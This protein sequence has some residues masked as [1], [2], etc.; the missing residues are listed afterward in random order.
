M[1]RA[2]VFKST[3]SPLTRLDSCPR[4]VA[5]PTVFSI[6]DYHEAFIADSKARQEPYSTTI[7]HTLDRQKVEHVPIYSHQH[8]LFSPLAHYILI[9]GLGGLGRFICTWMAEHGA[10]NLN[11]ISRSGLAS[12]EAQL[13]HTAIIKT[14]A[15]LKVFAADACDLASSEAQLTHCHHKDRGLAESLCRRCLRPRLRPENLW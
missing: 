1:T 15:S 9:G 7:D 3:A 6:C 5:S 10:K 14:G 13:T 11:V 2:K 4:H 12:S 8:T